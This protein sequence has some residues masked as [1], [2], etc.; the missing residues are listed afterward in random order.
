MEEVVDLNDELKLVNQPWRP[1]IVGEANGQYIKIAK[2]AGALEWH[3]HDSEDEVFLCLEG[4]LLIEMR[5]KEVQLK[6]GQMFTVLKGVEHRP[7][8]LP[9]ASFL[10]FEPK[11]TE[12]LGGIE[13]ANTVN[14]EEQLKD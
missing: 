7:K 1:L 2:G 12:H 4:C 9:E 10:L 5:D 11:S 8:A 14:I 13:S 6:P 3:S